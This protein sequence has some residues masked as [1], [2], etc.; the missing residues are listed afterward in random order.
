MMVDPVL[1]KRNLLL[2]ILFIQN[3]LKI[4]ILLEKSLQ[5]KNVDILQ[6]LYLEL[7]IELGTPLAFK[8][9]KYLIFESH[10]DDL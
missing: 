2:H 5:K 8:L 7:I 6:I 9:K 1:I 10:Y 3:Y 4:K